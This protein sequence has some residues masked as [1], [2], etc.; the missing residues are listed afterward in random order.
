MKRRRVRGREER[1]V[2]SVDGT[3][4]PKRHELRPSCVLRVGSYCEVRCSARSRTRRTT[5]KRR[6]QATRKGSS[7]RIIRPI[8]HQRVRP[9]L[10]CLG[11][12]DPRHQLSC[13]L[14]LPGAGVPSLSRSPRNSTAF[15]TTRSLEKSRREKV[16]AHGKMGCTHFTCSPAAGSDTP[17][18]QRRVTSTHCFSSRMALAATT[19]SPRCSCK[20]T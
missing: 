5:A 18:K 9:E 20:C 2:D 10:H 4:G 1:D 8:H 13:V 16:A 17:A 7:F 19:L 14:H 3:A 12:S 6:G 11:H 15:P